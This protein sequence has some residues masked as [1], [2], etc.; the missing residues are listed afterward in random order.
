MESFDHEVFEFMGKAKIPGGAL[1]VVKDGRLVYA[2]G[3]GWAD[4]EKRIPVEA[5]SLFRIAS[6]SKP[7]T[8]VAVMKLVEE[9]D[10]N[11]T[12]RAFDI[13]RLPAVVPAGKS[14][15]PRLRSIT[16]DQLLHHTGG[17]D[18]EMSLDPMF[19]SQRICK[20]VGAGSPADQTSIIRFM[21]GQHLDFNPG[22]RYAYSN[23]G[24]C[25]L[26]RVI[27]RITGQ[28]YEAF[29]KEKVMAPIGITRMR[30]G[31]T[32]DGRQ[33]PGEV[34][35]YLPDNALETSLFPGTDR[36]V[37]QPY[38]GFNL[39]AMD[40][41][42]AWIASAVDLVRFAAALG[43]P[44]KCPCLNPRTVT[45][46]YE[47]PAPPAGRRSSGQLESDYYGCGWE[48]TS[49]KRI[50]KATY[51]HSGCLPGTSTWLVRRGDGVTWALLFNQRTGGAGERMIDSGLNRAAN[52]IS[53]WPTGNLF[54]QF[55]G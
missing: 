52:R 19:Q 39:E 53:D 49:K 23:F 3:Y 27:E 15:D 31:A 46:M 5:T 13:V 14:I 25:V 30:I 20:A 40:S 11:L 50:P 51:W 36:L 41:N 42:G 16:I 38:G 29:V 28:S 35:Y 7:F 54:D 21:L 4:R 12:D 45:L 44:D 33:A 1:A 17:W 34:R 43:E 9:G 10:L 55:K 2:R 48:V 22:T 37:P 47:P 6:I 26:G 32:L 24:Y 8:A 18:R